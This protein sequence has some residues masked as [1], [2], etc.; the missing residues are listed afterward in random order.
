M[1]FG[2]FGLGCRGRRPRQGVPQAPD[3]GG[4][5]QE[6]LL[7]LLGILGC[8]PL[9]F[10]SRHLRLL[11]RSRPCLLSIWMHANYIWVCSASETQL[12]NLYNLPITASFRD[13]VMLLA[14]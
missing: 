2:A 10:S 11:F 7:F 13:P 3:L 12:P 9:C 4:V 6:I 14:T 1:G 8:L 5:L